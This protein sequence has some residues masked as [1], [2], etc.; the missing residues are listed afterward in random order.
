MAYEKRK[1]NR[2]SNS[3]EMRHRSDR[4][5]EPGAARGTDRSDRTLGNDY[6]DRVAADVASGY[7]TKEDDDS[8]LNVDQ[9]PGD[10]EPGDRNHV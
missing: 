4:K 1:G 6:W 5:K 7:K 10:H 8:I 3:S 2:F 9:E